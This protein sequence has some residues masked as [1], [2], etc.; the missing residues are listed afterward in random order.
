MRN[1]DNGG[2]KAEKWGGMGK[3]GKIIVEIV[4]TTS[5]LVDRMPN[6]G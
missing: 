2:G 5:F 4:A 6:T 1:I 3:K